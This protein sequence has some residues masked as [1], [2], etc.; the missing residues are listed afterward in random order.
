M[1]PLSHLAPG[2]SVTTTLNNHT[3]CQ[4]Q[5]G[6][7]VL[8]AG[9][10]SQYP[11]AVIEPGASGT[12]KVIG[13]SAFTAPDASVSLFYVAQHCNIAGE[14]PGYWVG[15]TAADGFS[16]HSPACG[17]GSDKLREHFTGQNA[18]HATLTIDL[19]LSA[20]G[21]E[22]VPHSTPPQ[23]D[24]PNAAVRPMAGNCVLP[25]Q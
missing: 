7:G 12:W 1:P 2:R 8:L 9:H 10:L 21:L 6:G 24:N 22:S 14:G 5:L 16:Y 17:W 18:Y 13:W 11:P 23:H 4:L 15:N 20:I 25:I 19:S 3:P